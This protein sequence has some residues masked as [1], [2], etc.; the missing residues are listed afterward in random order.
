MSLFT[1]CEN[2]AS[3]QCFVTFPRAN[4]EAFAPTKSKILFMPTRTL[5]HCLCMP[6]QKNNVPMLETC[7]KI[8]KQI[9]TKLLLLNYS[10]KIFASKT[11]F[12]SATMFPELGKQGNIHFLVCLGLNSSSMTQDKYTV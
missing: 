7:R 1:C 12:V 10:C 4:Q 8:M 3:Y 11:N 5:I 9:E 2:N 6:Y